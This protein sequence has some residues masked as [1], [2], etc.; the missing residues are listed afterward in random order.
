[1]ATDVIEPTETI[2][3]VNKSTATNIQKY[4]NYREQFTRLKRRL[5]QNSF[6]KR[7]L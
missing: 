2:T 4:E 1:M 7:Y 3:V 5:I 6:L